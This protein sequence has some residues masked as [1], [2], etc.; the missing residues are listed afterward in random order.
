M[1]YRKLGGTDIEVS[2]VCQGCWSLVSK[3]WTWGPNALDESI[4]AIGASL[5]AGVNFFDAAEGYGE[6]ESEEILGRA[7]ADVRKDVIIATKVSSGRLDPKG[8]RDACEDSLRRLGTDYIDLYQIHWPSRDI[9]LAETLSAMEELMS[10][11]K[12]RAAGVSNF[13]VSYLRELASTGRVESNQLAYNLLF[14]PIEHEVLP[15]CIEQQMSILCYSS[16]AQGLLTG[17]FASPGDVPP[18]RARTRLFSGDREFSRHGEGGCEEEAF[19]ALAE[20]RRICDGLAQPMGR[21]SLAWLLA[22]KGVTSVIVGGRNPAQAAENAKAAE[23]DLDAATLDALTKASEPVKEKLAR[24]TDMW[25][26][27]SRME[28]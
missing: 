11:G 21:V 1:K 17:K 27:N 12:I 6:G 19:A 20:I 24:N 25:K 22:Q 15:M 13:G 4:A 23:L 28:R 18:E 8:L 7:V 26:H 5:E 2:A 14:R 3:D 10:E 16:L 9:P